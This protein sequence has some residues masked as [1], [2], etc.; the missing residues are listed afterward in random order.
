[1][2]IIFKITFENDYKDY[3]ED[4]FEE[5]NKKEINK[6][7]IFESELTAFVLKNGGKIEQIFEKVEE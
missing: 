4:D 3:D 5:Y 6:S 2:K 7:K 1:M